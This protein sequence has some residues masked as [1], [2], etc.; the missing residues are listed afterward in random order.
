MK[1]LTKLVLMLCLILSGAFCYA[2]GVVGTKMKGDG[3]PIDVIAKVCHGGDDKGNFIFPILDGH[4]LTV[5]FTENLGEV[6]V[7]ITTS[8]GG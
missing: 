8:T 3:T 7:E 5:A 4:M 6:A 1:K 2:K